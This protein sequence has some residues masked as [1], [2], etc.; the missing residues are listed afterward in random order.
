MNRVLLALLLLCAPLA[1][2]AAEPITY[3][4]V[5]NQG[6]EWILIIARQKSMFEAA[7]IDLQYVSLPSSAA[8]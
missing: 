7:G 8:V 6:S 1:A 2:H 3:G 4:I 5:G